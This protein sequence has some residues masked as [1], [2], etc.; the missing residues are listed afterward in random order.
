[1]TI[2]V[3]VGGDNLYLPDLLF[4]ALLPAVA[5]SRGVPQIVATR[6]TATAIRFLV[7]WLFAAIISDFVNATDTP[8]VLKGLSRIA[9]L[10][11][12]LLVLRSIATTERRLSALVAGL[13]VGLLLTFVLYPNGFA[14]GDPWK[15]GVATPTSLF[16]ALIACR[17]WRSGRVV[18]APGIFALLAVA[19]LLLGFRSQAGVTA[20]AAVCLLVA[21]QR[22]ADAGNERGRSGISLR[23]AAA[24]IAVVLVAVLGVRVYASLASSGAL[25]VAA[26]QKYESQAASGQNLLLASR[27]ETR[28]SLAAIRDAPWLGHGSNP[29]DPR[30]IDL[31]PEPNR[32]LAIIHNDNLIP[33]HSHVLGSWVESGLAGGVFWLYVAAVCVLAI[34]RTSSR[35]SPLSPLIL[36]VACNELWDLSFSPYAGDRHFTTSIFLIILLAG[37]NA[38]QVASTG[39]LQRHQLYSARFT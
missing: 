9:L 26:Q 18:L 37:A 19:N 27:F 5:L 36:Y 38:Q 1:M 17:L 2:F 20:A 4:L 12:G 10:L 8:D 24:G 21:R 6:P 3:R 11:V 22:N 16:C 39:K 30:Y 35:Q 29:Q 15:F 7:I 25:G 34:R 23:S 32:T 28:P 14:A 33:T 31:L 13:G